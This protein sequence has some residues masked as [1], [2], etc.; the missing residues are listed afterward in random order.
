MIIG[1]GGLQSKI[2]DMQID[3]NK[4]EE[5]YLGLFKRQLKPG[6]IQSVD[7]LATDEGTFWMSPEERD[8]KRHVCEWWVKQKQ[9]NKQEREGEGEGESF[10]IKRKR[11]LYKRNCQGSS[12]TSRRQ[13]YS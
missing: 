7:L 9:K 3:A 12:K 8:E 6:A 4:K 10:K 13:W 5:G 1:Y 2:R 11:D